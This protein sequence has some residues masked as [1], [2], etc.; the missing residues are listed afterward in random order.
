MENVL[1]Q[2]PKGKT[3]ADDKVRSLTRS[4]TARV[5]RPKSSETISFS[6]KTLLCKEGNTSQKDSSSTCRKHGRTGHSL[7]Q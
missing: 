6:S 7:P 4:I 2:E 1:A 3:K 5:H